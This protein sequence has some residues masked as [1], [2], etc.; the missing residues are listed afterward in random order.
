MMQEHENF[1]E[2]FASLTDEEFFSIYD[3]TM[4]LLQDGGMPEG[5]K[6]FLEAVVAEQKKRLARLHEESAR[7]EAERQFLEHEI[8]KKERER[9]LLIKERE[10]LE[11]NLS[12]LKL[13]GNHKIGRNEPCPCGSGK[14]YKHCCGR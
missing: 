8:A 5:G 2:K 11:G 6:P 10:R 12:S 13:S 1:S 9:E 14:K 7:L 4:S 3:E